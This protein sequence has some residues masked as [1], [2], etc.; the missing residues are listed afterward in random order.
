ML[1]LFAIL[2]LSETMI[3]VFRLDRIL[4][5]PSMGIRHSEF[6]PKFQQLQRIVE[7]DGGIDC[8]FI[9]NSTVNNALVP[10]IFSATFLDITGEEMRCYN[11]A[12]DAIPASV[13]AGLAG[14][15]AEEFHPDILIYGL[16]ARDL[17]LSPQDKETALIEDADWYRYRQGEFNVAGWLYEHSFLFRYRELMFR[18]ARLDFEE[19]FA[20]DDRG[21]VGEMGFIPMTGQD[22]DTRIPPSQDD[23]LFSVRRSFEVLFDYAIQPAQ[24]LGLE[25]L[26]R[27]NGPAMQVIVVEMPSPK[28]RLNFFKDGEADYQRFLNQVSRTASAND[29][30]FITTTDQDLFPD[31]AWF[32]YSHVNEKGAVIF[33]EWLAER[34]SEA[35][36]T[37]SR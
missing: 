29:V 5:E 19:A 37:T 35:V 27:L 33:S 2:L 1:F 31:D 9:G 23:A 7:R 26:M 8:V 22:V 14:I 6:G 3:R 18:L 30:P 32:D 4:K 16:V 11:F 28:T 25:G 24:L 36:S 12:I 13:A 15:I 17:A 10:E 21:I 34:V 20:D